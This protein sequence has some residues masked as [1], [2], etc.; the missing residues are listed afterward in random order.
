[1]VMNTKKDEKIKCPR[2]EIYMRKEEVEVTGSNI[3]IDFCIQCH[4]YW[5]DKGELNKYIK[6][7]VIDKNLKRTEGIQSWSKTVCPRC[8]GKISLKFIEDL[9]V[10][11]CDDCGGLWLDHGELKQLQDKDFAAFK[12][13]RLKEVI[14]GLKRIT[15]VKQ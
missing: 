9:E 12:E 5:F 2:C 3:T 10:D 8:D 6:T 11:H 14:S 4:S 7:N 1:M 13:S 15:K